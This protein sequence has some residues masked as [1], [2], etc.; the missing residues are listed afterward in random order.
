MFK[1]T[2]NEGTRLNT[3]TKLDTT[4]NKHSKTSNLPSFLL[5]TVRQVG[6][7]STHQHRL[8]Y[9]GWLFL[10]CILFIASRSWS[11]WWAELRASR[12]I[13]VNFISLSLSSFRNCM[14]VSASLS[15]HS[16]ILEKI[17]NQTLNETIC[18]FSSGASPAFISKGGIKPF[19]SARG[20]WQFWVAQLVIP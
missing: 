14:T 12:R 17:E 6:Q 10:T 1:L 15:V 7:P 16:E 20:R 13:S 5:F 9:L 4:S 3:G 11:S 8:Q 2:F 18:Y 19:Y